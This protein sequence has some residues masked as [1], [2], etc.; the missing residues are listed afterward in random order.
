VIA[1]QGLIFR[2]SF[3]VGSTSGTILSLDTW[4]GNSRWSFNTSRFPNQEPKALLSSGAVSKGRF[5]IGSENHALY[6]LTLD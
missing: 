2:N 5:F 1:S 6:C 4:T 3:I